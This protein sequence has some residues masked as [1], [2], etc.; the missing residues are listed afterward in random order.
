[1]K[2]SRSPGPTFLKDGF[3][4]IRLY[5]CVGT[6]QQVGVA[7]STVSWL[8]CEG[9]S[10]PRAPPATEEAVVLLSAPSSSVQPTPLYYLVRTEHTSIAPRH[11][12]LA[13]KH[14]RTRGATGPRYGCTAFPPAVLAVS[15]PPQRGKTPQITPST[16]TN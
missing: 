4:S 13:L 7:F 6:H 10:A 3:V 15:E 9:D 5:T 2:E 1:M 8:A 16:N 12:P 11:Q 14:S